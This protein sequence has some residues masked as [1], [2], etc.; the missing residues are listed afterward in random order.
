MVEK[1]PPNPNGYVSLETIANA[2]DIKYEEVDV[3]E[4]GGT[5]RIRQMTV[6]AMT[7]F[8]EENFDLE[9]GD[10]TLK[11]RRFL[12]R[13]LARTLVDEDNKPLFDNEEAGVALLSNRSFATVNRL[14]N[15][16]VEMNRLSD[17]DV[18]EAKKG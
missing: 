1:A 3:P 16:A 18:E 14:A 5:A 2:S 12:T 4:W 7:Q 8:Y 17:A 13:L 9:S 6:D 10:A 11:D 15:V